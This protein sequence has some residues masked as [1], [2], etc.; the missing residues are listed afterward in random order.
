MDREPYYG[1]NEQPDI[2]PTATE[3]I[4][5]ADSV[6]FKYPMDS[7]K[8][9]EFAWRDLQRDEVIAHYE[10]DE[11]QEIRNRLTAAGLKC[12]MDFEI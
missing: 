7:V 1:K 4:E 8:H 2:C 3:L 10:D 9:I 6:N 12:G 5:F 11:L